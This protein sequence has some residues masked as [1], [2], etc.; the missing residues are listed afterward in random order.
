MMAK[1]TEALFVLPYN[2]SVRIEAASN[3]HTTSDAAALLIRSVI[4]RTGLIEFLTARLYDPR[5]QHR[6]QYSLAQLLLQWLL[7]LIQGW[8]VLWTAQLH[9]DAAFGASTSIKQGAVEAGRTLA[10]QPTL[11]RLLGKADNPSHL[12]AAVQKLAIEHMLVR[13][14]GRRCDEVVIDVDA[15]PMDAHGKQLG[16]AYHGHYKCTVFL[17]LIAS[18]GET[19][20][21][22]GT[23]L[24]PGNRREVT[25]CEDFMV[26]MAAD[27]VIIR[28]DAG[29]NSGAV[30]TRLETEGH[31]YVMR[32][33]KNKV[34]EALA[35]PYVEDCS[36]ETKTYFELEY[37]TIFISTQFFGIA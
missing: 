34:L 35:T 10:S 36:Y 4:A 25:D 28:L 27:R 26:S 12:E 17:P 37:P 11:L 20:D 32:L 33:R 5:N 13:N 18:C 29:F 24:R 1:S 30:F 7:Q 31:H 23:Q 21:V 19:G 2:Q 3:D 14:G 16:S 9:T 22:L 15:M 8:G 6:I